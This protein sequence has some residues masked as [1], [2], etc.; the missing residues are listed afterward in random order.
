MAGVS[1][2][3]ELRQI[4][5]VKQNEKTETKSTKLGIENEKQTKSGSPIRYS[6][7]GYE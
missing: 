4:Q 2:P 6:G 3:G 7:L 5:G 1:V